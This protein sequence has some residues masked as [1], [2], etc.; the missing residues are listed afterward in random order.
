M[1]ETTS[2]SRWP[3]VSHLSVTKQAKV[4]YFWT[5]LV[6][7]VL[8]IG[9]GYIFDLYYKRAGID[10]VTICISSLICV[11][12]YVIVLVPSAL[13]FRTYNYVWTMLE[14]IQSFILIFILVSFKGYLVNHYDSISKDATR[15][16]VFIAYVSAAS[17]EETIKVIVY[18]TPLLVQRNNRTIHDLIYFGF[19]SGVSFAT[20]ENLIVTNQG[21]T[22]AFNR[23]LWC[24]G[25]HTSDCISGCLI[26]AYM[27]SKHHMRLPDKWFI[28]PFILLVPIALHG[29]FDLVIFLSR[30]LSAAWISY[31]SFF[32]GFVSIVLALGLLY[33]FRRTSEQPTPPIQIVKI[34]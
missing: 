18:S 28:Y 4:R 22:I 14:F 34:V 26:L 20:I 24:T 11:L 13:Y 17:I 25:T 30:D 12:G 2:D 15:L 31:M 16:S 1:V 32:V 27:K 23:F 6:V 7:S 21:V 33:P 19:V 9:L 5:V 3:T 10:P 29:T 8:C